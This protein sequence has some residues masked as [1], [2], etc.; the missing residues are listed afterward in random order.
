MADFTSSYNLCINQGA[1]YSRVF[2]WQQNCGCGLVGGPQP[3]NLTG[4]TAAMQ[5]K[6]YPLSTD[7]LYDASADIVLGGIAGTIA[8]T[9]DATD[10]ETFTWW[11]GVY[12]MLLT[13]SGGQVTRLLMGS[14]TVSAGVT[15]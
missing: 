1:T 15:P 7:V 11:Q 12:D 2:Y 9:I 5:I 3:V 6:Q 14:V 4:Y 8:L 10:T 13:S